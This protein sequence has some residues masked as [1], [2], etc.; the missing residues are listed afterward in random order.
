MPNTAETIREAL[1]KRF[2]EDLPVDPRLDGLDELARIA[3]HRTHR[4]YRAQAV[5]PALLRLLCACALSAPSKSDLQQADILVVRDTRLRQTIA[6]LLPDMPWVGEAPAF[7][8]FLA[9][10]R[11]LER[12]AE[13]REKPFPN[14]HLDQFFNA[15]V[16]A[17]LVLATFMRAA[18][19]VGLG[20]CPISVIRDHAAV[21]GELL[22]LPQRVIPVA[23]MCV[24]WPA[25]AGG[26]TARLPL[27]LTLHEDR[28][29]EGDLAASID[30]YDR[31]RAAMWPYARQRAPE[32]WGEAAFYGWSEDKARQ[33]GEPQRADFGAYVRAKGFGLD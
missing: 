28:Y 31:R 30:A 8:V 5:E 26:I 32:K 6:D 33:Y 9:N 2:G 22:Q 23:G 10:G 24:G 17:G 29:D 15:A 7:L 18:A 14:D 12:I 27:D 16:D 21:V 4:R 13:L 3:A 20:C 25:Q 11:R 19:A 1:A